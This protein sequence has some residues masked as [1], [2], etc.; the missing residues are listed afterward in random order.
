MSYLSSIGFV[1]FYGL[2]PS[3]NWLKQ[4]NID[5]S[6]N[7]DRE[8]NVLLSEVSDIRHILHTLA[9]ALPLACDQRQN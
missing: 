1:P 6:E 7:D 9:D 5:L 3:I 2:S 8:I 4:S